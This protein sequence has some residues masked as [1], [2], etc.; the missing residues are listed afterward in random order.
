MSAIWKYFQVNE[1][2]KSKAVSKICKS[3]FSRGGTNPNSYNTSN[4]I[5][6][7]KTQHDAEY[8][9][10]SHSGGKLQQPTLPQ[11]LK[12]RE[13]MSR[14]NPHAMKITEALTQ[15][16][17]LDDQPLSVIEDIGFRRLLS[18]LEPRYEIPSRQYITDREL[19]KLYD[20]VKRHIQSLLQDVSAISLTTDIWTSSVSPVSLISLTAQWVDKDFTLQRAVLH[21]KQFRGSHTSQAIEDVF[22]EMLRKW[23]VPKTLIHVVLRDNAKNMIKAMTDAGFQSLPCF[24]HTLQLVVNEGLLVQRSVTDAVA[25]GRKIVRHFKHSTLAYSR[26]E[27]IQLQLNQPTKRL[28]QDVQTRWNSTFYMIQSLIEQK[29]AL[30]IYG[31]ENELPE[32][33]AAHQWALLEKTVAVLAP[34]E[35]LT[36]KVSCSDALASDV[37]PAVTVLLRIL[38][39]ETD[40]DQ[41]IKTMKSTLAAAVK[42]RFTDMEKIPLY[43]IAMLLDPRYKDRFFLKRQHCHGC[44]RNAE[45]VIAECEYRRAK[46]ES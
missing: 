2:D 23:G 40:D 5:K 44:Q 46:G 4:L 43:C 12:K 6:H 15:Y 33:L 18:V 42:R 24:A 39:R 38:N 30:G 26:L 45:G 37:I 34:F 35:E 25:I 36:R 17:A 7:L 1:D 9:E 8:K 19:P 32:N 3:K 10:F 11:M 21:A 22:D 28:Q 29:R 13:K 20:F 27:D 16:I 14:D 41:G 31:S